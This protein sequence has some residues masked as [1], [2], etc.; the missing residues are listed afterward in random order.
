M[1]FQRQPEVLPA[2]NSDLDTTPE[3]KR[4]AAL[5]VAGRDEMTGA[6]RFELLDMLG[7]LPEEKGET[8]DEC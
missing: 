2:I 7:L 6:E 4:R 8:H 5:L 3:Q 1:A